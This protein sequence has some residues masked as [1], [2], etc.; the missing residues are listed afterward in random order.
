MLL[1]ND[2]NANIGAIFHFAK[3]LSERNEVFSPL[4]SLL[5]RK[6]LTMTGLDIKRERKKNG[7]TQEKLAELL[8]VSKRTVINYENSQVI[9]KSKTALIHLVFKKES[10]KS[11]NT[12]GDGY[13]LKEDQVSYFN[14]TPNLRLENKNGNSFEE[15]N[16]GSYV[17]TVDEIPFEA[18]ASYLESLE[19]PTY[20]GIEFPQV[21]FHVDKF[22]KGNYKAFKI[23]GDSMNG[24][25]LDDT[26][27]GA[28][29]L[30]RELGRD[31]WQDGFN[32]TQYGW[33]IMCDC[34]IFHKDIVN[35]DLE[36]GTI[37]C[38]SRN[39]SP[40]YSDFELE[41]NTLKKI[42]KVVKRT[43]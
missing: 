35:L 10:E 33:I 21:S 17:I 43:F 23:K 34:N 39:T 1:L 3:Y 20:E 12:T 13:L 4:F 7:W 25:M 41:L 14:A 32:K 38:H 22:G 11:E 26:P 6:H 37:T 30:A 24:G 31:H 9:P 15:L 28:S 27:D 40:E 16:D 5:T 8:G 18:H 36:K 42:F 2:Y 19:N 29:V